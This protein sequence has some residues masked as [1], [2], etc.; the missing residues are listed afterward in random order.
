MD[1]QI[2]PGYVRGAVI[3][4]ILLILFLTSFFGFRAGRDLAKSTLTLQQVQGVLQG[5]DYFYSD[6]DR[7]PSPTEYES[8]GVMA[9]YLSP[10][11]VPGVVSK[12]CPTT[13]TYDTFDERAFT[14]RY[15]LPRATAGQ[16]AGAHQL[17]ER[18]I[19]AWK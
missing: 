4:I 10:I 18:D 11:P 5:L 17:T 16:A 15:C 13:I 3:A 1:I 7:Y 2:Q 14:L 8:K 6:Q 19:P 9:W 12:Q